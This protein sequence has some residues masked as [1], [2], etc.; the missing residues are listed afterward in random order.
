MGPHL[1]SF[2]WP[3]G[4][5]PCATGWVFLAGR[6]GSCRRW[7]WRKPRSPVHVGACGRC[8]CRAQSCPLNLLFPHPGPELRGRWGRGAHCTSPVPT[9]LV[10]SGS[11][12]RSLGVG[13]TGQACGSVFPHQD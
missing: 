6:F 5:F 8:R 11:H 9:C 1:N 10:S 12:G 13:W 4:D 3:C 7:G 2:A